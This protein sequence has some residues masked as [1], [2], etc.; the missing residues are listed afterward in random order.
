MKKALCLLATLALVATASAE[1]TFF[2]TV[3]DGTLGVQG[4]NKWNTGAANMLADYGGTYLGAVG[5]PEYDVYVETE[6]TYYLWARS[7]EA[8]YTQIFGLRFDLT[9]T[10]PNVT[11]GD[12][13]L[14]RHEKTTGPGAQQHVRWDNAAWIP[15]VAGTAVA[16]TSDGIWFGATGDAFPFPYDLGQG[17]TALL[18]IFKISDTIAKGSEGSILLSTV[19]QDGDPVACH[20]AAT[21]ATYYPDLT[22]GL[23]DTFSQDGTTHSGE[24]VS[25]VPEPA[26]L[27]LVGLAG[28]FLRRR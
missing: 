18:G 14:Y 17:D 4:A 12:N 13:L 9:S 20:D 22:L 23:G 16:V 7:T 5:V 8:A 25:L 28:L 10:N 6:E 11:V 1:I 24:I 27:L 15:I 19:Y 21:G 3:D 26:S 2:A